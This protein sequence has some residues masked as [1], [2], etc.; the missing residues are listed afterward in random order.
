MICD[1]TTS[2]TLFLSEIL[3]YGYLSCTW[4]G[5]SISVA[6]V[7]LPF[8]MPLPHM[9]QLAYYTQSVLRDF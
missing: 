4:S 1:A 7:R 2:L 5:Y 9:R 3:L 6:P 8:R